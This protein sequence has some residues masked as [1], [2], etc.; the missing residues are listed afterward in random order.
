MWKDFLWPLLVMQ[1][2]EKQPL[3]VALHRLSTTGNQIP[4]TEMVAGLAIASVPMVL[5]FLLF[6]RH[7]L[8]GL[9]AGAVKG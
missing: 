4:P 9:S 5:I 2:P 3:S 6:Q 7:I 8:A 1:D